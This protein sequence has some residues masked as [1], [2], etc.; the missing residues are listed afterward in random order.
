M[1][2]YIKLLLTLFCFVALRSQAQT[3]QA[4]IYGVVSDEN[5]QLIP[6]ASVMVKNESTG[7]ISRT[8]T[9]SKGEYNIREL[10]LGGPYVVTVTYVGYANQQEKGS[11]LSQGDAARVNVVMKVSAVNMNEVKVVGNSLRNKSENFGA[12]TTVSARDISKLPVNGRNFTTLIDLSPL[13]RGSNLSGQLASST[14]FTI[15]GTTARNPTSGGGSNSRTGAPYIISMEAIREFKVVTNQYDVTYGRSGGGT[16]STVTKAGTNTFTGSAF[17]FSRA[18]WLSSPNDIRGA[19]RTND[20]STNQFGFS[21]GGPIIKDKAH[22]F[23]TWDRQADARPLQLA[24]I[25]SPEDEKRLNITQSTLDQFQ[26]IA[27]SKYG[28][29]NAAQFGSFDKKRSTDAV[30]ARIDWQLNEKNLLTIRNNFVNDRNFQGRDDNTAI[31]MYEVYGDANTYNNSLLATLRTVLNPRVTNELKLQHLYTFE[32]SVPNKQLPRENIPRAIVER[33]QSTINNNPVFTSIQLGGQRYSPEHFYNNIVQLVDNVY[34]NTNKANFTFGTD[35]MYSHLNSLYGSEMNGRFYFTGMTN[36]DNKTPYRYAREIALADDPSLNQNILNAG[37]Y[38]QM[39]TRL[40]RGLEMILGIRA[41][42]TTYMNKANFNQTVFDELGLRTDNPLNTLQIQPR[43]QFNWDINEKHTD[44]LRLGAGIFGSDINNYAMINNMLFDGTKVLS[45][46]IT[47]NNVPVPDFIEYRKDPSKAPGKELFDQLG[48]ARIGTINTNAKDA[49]IPVVYKANISYNHLFSDRLKAGITFFTSIAR[50]NYMYVDRN[51]VDQPYFR[52]ANEGNRGVY[53]P[54]T[55][56]NTTN[57]VADWTQGR[58]STQVGRVLELNAGG[59]VN[60]YAFVADVNWRYFRDG[61]FTLSYTWNDAK[62][63]TSFNGDVANTAT[64]SLMVKED[65]RN[66]DAMSYSDN[67]FRHKIVFYGTL[68]SWKGFSVGV[69][70]S[71]LGGTRYSLAVNGNVN[72]DFVNS[73]DLAYIFDVNNTAVPEKYRTAITGILNNPSVD[74]SIKDYIRK[75]MGTIAERNAGV[76][77]FYGIWDLRIGKKFNIYKSHNIELS[78]DLFN[79]ANLL[80]KGWGTNKSLGKQNI[81]SLGGFDAASSTYNYNVN[82]N[83]GVVTPSGN[84]WQ[85]QFGIRYGF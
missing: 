43:I 7:F 11:Y 49:R 85:I 77:G 70:Y 34:F 61:E 31:N 66:L 25:Q 84:P 71:G 45:V 63:N 52:L 2:S 16:V 27:R 38:A 62:D 30:F 68:P 1:R 67:Q 73:N 17:M 26:Q 20:F 3:T 19:K 36:F 60:Q 6:G 59:K 22:F 81:Y 58:K 69:R 28:V 79:V 29:S 12:A 44:Y 51:M 75:S 18:D 48:L 72:G 83:T 74:N 39:Q 78:G 57:G 4:S 82:V 24:D 65:P 33:V 56:I 15:D 14:N 10:P 42:Y 8:V 64:L 41:D 21:L 13:S 23:L 47:G 40:A 37:L 32:E 50:N 55:T 76:N 46:D 54:A 53:V 9:N 35:I 80:N 5:K